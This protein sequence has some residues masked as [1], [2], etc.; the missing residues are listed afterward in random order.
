MGDTFT[1]LAIIV[2]WAQGLSMGYAMWGERTPFW[3]GFIRG[4]TFGLWRGKK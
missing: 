1:V 2:A 3:Q 4:L